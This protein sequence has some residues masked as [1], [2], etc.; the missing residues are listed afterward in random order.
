MSLSKLSGVS[1][2][3]RLSS[4]VVELYP[5]QDPDFI[6]ALGERELAQ[7]IHQYYQVR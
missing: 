4:V 5:S 2:L 3:E 1:I 7:L 6:D